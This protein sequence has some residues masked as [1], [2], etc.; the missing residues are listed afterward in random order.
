[1]GR[2]TGVVVLL[3]LAPSGAYL[4]LFAK[5]GVPSTVGFLVSDII[6]VVAMV[7]GVR[8][9]RA[10]RFNE[11]RRAMW[12]VL[13]QLS[14]AVSSRAML[15]AF[16]ALNVEAEGAYLLSLWLPVVLSAVAVETFVHRRA[17]SFT[18]WRKHDAR[19]AAGDLDRR[20]PGLRG[21]TTH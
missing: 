6:V 13:A 14:V 21:A 9:A 8:S 11:H 19:S 4:S 18:P 20:T 12:H 7:A 16:D 5:G 15:F 10:G 17:G 1:M 2:V 3:G